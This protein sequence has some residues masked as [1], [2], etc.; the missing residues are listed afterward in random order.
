M[1]QKSIFTTIFSVSLVTIPTL[2]I[3]QTPTP[4]PRPVPA[5]IPGDSCEA[6][7]LINGDRILY[8][9]SYINNDNL[10]FDGKPVEVDMIKNDAFA[11]HASTHYVGEFTFTGATATGTPLSFQ[12]QP[13]K[14]EITI[15]HAGRTILGKCGDI[16]S[17]SMNNK[18]Y[19]A[20]K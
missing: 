13:D 8:R 17:H 16:V 2:I 11:A 4:K 1:W 7:T 5:P 6:K 12:L 10:R 9:T 20:L 14:N 3:A 19:L 15:T 18:H